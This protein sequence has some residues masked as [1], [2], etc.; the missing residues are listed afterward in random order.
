MKKKDQQDVNEKGGNIRAHFQKIQESNM[1]SKH[2]QFCII[3][4]ILKK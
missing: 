4:I 1:I 3:F 2:T